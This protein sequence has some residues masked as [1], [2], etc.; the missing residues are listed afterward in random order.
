MKPF[1]KKAPSGKWG[2]DKKFGTRSSSDR[3][4]FGRDFAK[5]EMFQ[6]TCSECGNACEVPFKPTGRKPILC[7]KCFKKD[8]QTDQNR[9]GG[10]SS[11]GPSFS[12]RR[13]APR[14]ESAQYRNRGTDSQSDEFKKI[15]AKLDA[16]LRALS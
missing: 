14:Q 12:D 4:P 6:A 3:K 7:D 11:G 10:A 13:G 15:H 2:G 5:T 16:I 9:F 1:S 8:R